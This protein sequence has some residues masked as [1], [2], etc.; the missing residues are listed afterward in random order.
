MT[1]LLGVSVGLFCTLVISS[2][3]CTYIFGAVCKSTGG[4]TVCNR[5]GILNFRINII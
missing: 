1:V 4:K 3:S 2:R 5:T